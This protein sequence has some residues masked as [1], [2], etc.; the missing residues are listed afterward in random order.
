RKRTRSSLCP[1]TC[2]CSPKA[3]S[4]T[5]CSCR[6]PSEM[7]TQPQPAHDDAIRE[8]DPREALARQRADALLIDVREDDERAGGMP[9]GAVGLARGEIP[10]S[11]GGIAPDRR[12]EIVTICASGKRSLLAATTLRELG[13]ANVASI[14]GGFARWQAEGLPVDPGVLDR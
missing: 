6:E 12:R 9:A 13:Y 2:A 4:S 5:C 1:R 3:I 11:I 14:R 8:V 7:S 10:A